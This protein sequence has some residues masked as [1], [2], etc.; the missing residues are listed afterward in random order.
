VQVFRLVSQAHTNSAT[1][2]WPRGHVEVDVQ[3]VQRLGDAFVAHA[4][5]CGV[6]LLKTGRCGRQV[7]V[8]FDDDQ[9]I[10]HAPFFTLGVVAT[11]SCRARNSDVDSSSRHKVSKSWKEGQDSALVAISSVSRRNSASAT[12]FTVPVLNSTWKSKPSNLIAH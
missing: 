2:A 7:N 12:T 4:V 5:R 6:C 11:S 3:L 10:L 9:A 1:M 8:A